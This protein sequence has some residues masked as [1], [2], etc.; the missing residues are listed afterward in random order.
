LVVSAELVSPAMACML[1][2]SISL[3]RI[4][5]FTLGTASGTR[6]SMN[7]PRSFAGAW[8]WSP[9]RP[10]AFLAYR[11]VDIAFIIP[12]HH[13]FLCWYLVKSVARVRAWHRFRFRSSFDRSHISYLKA[14]QGKKRTSQF[15]SGSG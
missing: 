14:Q 8:S 3:S 9:C 1:Q 7:Q 10:S 15:R 12:C 4:G 2:Y 11:L 5:Y 6:F 13:V